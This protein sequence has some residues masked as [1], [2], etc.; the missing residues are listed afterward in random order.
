[1]Q[2][3][4]DGRTTLATGASSGIGVGIACSLLET[5]RTLNFNSLVPLLRR[6]KPSSGTHPRTQGLRHAPALDGRGPGELPGADRR[7]GAPITRTSQAA[8]IL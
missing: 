3:R 6:W 4:L 7:V 2:K 5:V 8:G 1:M